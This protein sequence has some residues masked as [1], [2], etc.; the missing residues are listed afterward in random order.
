M[1][2][3]RYEMV[4]KIGMLSKSASPFGD[5]RQVDTPRTALHESMRPGNITLTINSCTRN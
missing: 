2:D 1:T 4:K 3:I 5:L